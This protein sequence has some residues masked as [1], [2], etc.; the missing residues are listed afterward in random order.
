[1]AKTYIKYIAKWE[2]GAK[3]GNAVLFFPEYAANLGNI[4]CYAHIGQHS[5][6]ALEYYRQCKNPNTT[7]Q[8]AAIA[9]LVKEYENTC[10]GGE[11]LA[12]VYRDKQSYRKERYSNV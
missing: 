8:K 6:A 1:M 10:Y 12:Q 2:G 9:S 7:Q 11:T 4:V 5:E 3:Q